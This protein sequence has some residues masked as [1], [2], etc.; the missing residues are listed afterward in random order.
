MGWKG[1]ESAGFESE[2]SS[3]SEVPSHFEEDWV[4]A[5]GLKRAGG[6][7]PLDLELNQKSDKGRQA[8]KLTSS[9]KEILLRACRILGSR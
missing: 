2:K 7:G 6:H 1:K 3:F 4:R 8:E 9:E 5:L